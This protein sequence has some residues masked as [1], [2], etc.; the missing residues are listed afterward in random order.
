MINL[1]LAVER[2]PAVRHPK[3][4]LAASYVQLDKIDDAEW[5][6]TELEVEHPEITITHLKKVL[7]LNDKDLQRRLFEDL[8]TA[9]MAE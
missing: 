4:Y 9:G 5:L 3:F 6:V 1:E 2:N 8:R 7:A